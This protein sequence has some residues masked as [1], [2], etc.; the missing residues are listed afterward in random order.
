MP[1]FP[2][3]T[4][5][6]LPGF[7]LPFGLVIAIIGLRLALGQKPWLPRTCW[8]RNRGHLQPRGRRGS[9]KHLLP[10]PIL[11]IKAN[12]AYAWSHLD[13]KDNSDER[14]SN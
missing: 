3:C 2:F 9:V 6:P 14:Y 7:S 12:R 8:T 10:M 1:A 5:I 4:P 13:G 11:V